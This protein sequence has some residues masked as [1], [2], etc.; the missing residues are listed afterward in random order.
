MKRLSS[1]WKIFIV[2]SLAFALGVPFEATNPSDGTTSLYS[3]VLGLSF[4]VFAVRLTAQE[5]ERQGWQF[6]NGVAL[7]VIAMPLCILILLIGRILGK[8]KQK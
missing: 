1:N 7:A 6:R 5:A 2:L 4:W 3:I 8:S